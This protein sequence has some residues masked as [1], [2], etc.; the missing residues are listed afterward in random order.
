MPDHRPSQLKK[1]KKHGKKLNK[2]HH[3]DHRKVEKEVVEEHDESDEAPPI[4]RNRDVKPKSRKEKALYD[5][6]AK[7]DMA[8]PD[9]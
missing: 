1:K 4:R 3:K 6:I 5:R 9:R 2:K 7:K 8:R